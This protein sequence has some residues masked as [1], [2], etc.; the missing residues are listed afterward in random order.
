MAVSNRTRFE[1]LRRC[2]FACYYCGVPAA[3]GL[4]PLHIDHV[5]PLSL[6]GTD[7]PWNLVSACW[8]CNMG[9]TNG[10]PTDELIR[11]VRNDYCGYTEAAG[12]RVGQCKFCSVPIL[13]Y[14]DEEPYDEC[15]GCNIL[16]DMGYRAGLAAYQRKGM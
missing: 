3:L 11:L 12:G 8:D 16:L 10:A 7:D 13:L 9:K 2:N 1:V 6:G 4:K 14:E 15:E 5:I